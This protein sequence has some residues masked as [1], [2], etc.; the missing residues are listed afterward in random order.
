MTK[1]SVSK[2]DERDMP[3]RRVR[4]RDVKRLEIAL[5]VGLSWDRAIC[6][7]RFFKCAFLEVFRSLGSTCRLNPCAGF[8]GIGHTNAFELCCRSITLFDWKSVYPPPL[9]I[10]Q[11]EIGSSPPILSF[12]SGIRSH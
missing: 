12:S 6:M 7:F 2:K 5:A 3:M 10:S 11:D 4:H 8:F 9:F 1:A